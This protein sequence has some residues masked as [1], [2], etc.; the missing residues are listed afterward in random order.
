MPSPSEQDRKIGFITV[1][2]N[3]RNGLLGGFLVLNQFGRPVEFHCTAPVHANRAQEILYGNTLLPFLYGEQIAKT[4]IARTDSRPVVVLTDNPFVLAGAPLVKYPVGLV[5]PR[6]KGDP[7][8]EKATG[9]SNISNPAE[10]LPLNEIIPPV[11]GLD[12]SHWSEVVKGN[13]HLALPDSAMEKGLS[14]V[15][16]LFLLSIDPTEP[17]ERI[18]LA[19]EEAQKAG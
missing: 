6:K 2:V 7:D 19:I 16:D 10:P 4:L 9:A 3:D 11:P 8:A 1:V 18:R 5:F 15:L 13:T 14:E 17:F 12:L